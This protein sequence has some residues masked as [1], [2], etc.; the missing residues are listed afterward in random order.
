MRPNHKILLVEDEFSLRAT[1][2][3][4]LGVQFDVEAVENLA[5][6]R[7]ALAANTFDVVLLDKG[8][9]DGD[10]ISLIPEIKGNSPTT[11]VVVMTGDAEF[12][13][14]IKCIGAGADDYIV[15][16]GNTVP[17]LFVRIPVAIDHAQLKARNLVAGIAPELKLPWTAASATKEAYSSFMNSAEKAFLSAALKLF[18][19]DAVQ[20]ANS[21]G[22]AKSTIFKKIS[23][24]GIS[25]KA[26]ER[27]NVNENQSH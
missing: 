12:N 24:L 26:L 19:G 1:L 8:L 4:Y 14:V 22:L 3:K 5:G 27:E 21:I 13:S 10:G 25:R 2:V 6:A 7:A 18:D 23:E 17:E 15:K 20:T 11:A 9:P 16:S